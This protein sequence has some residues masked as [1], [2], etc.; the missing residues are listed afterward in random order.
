MA[1]FIILVFL[2]GAGLFLAMRFI[3][4]AKEKLATVW[5]AVVAFLIAVVAWTVSWWADIPVDVPPM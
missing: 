1:G 3:P 5:A 4:G 2:I